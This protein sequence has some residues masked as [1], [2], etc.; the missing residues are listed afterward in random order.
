MTRRGFTLFEV[1]VAL[2][3]F[4]IAVTGLAIGLQS[5]VEA[6]LSARQRALA[7]FVIESRLAAAMTD[8]PL[9]GKRTIDGATN[10]GISV[11]ETFEQVELQD[12]NGQIIPGMWKLQVTAEFGRDPTK[13]QAEILVYRP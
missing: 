12:T 9:D 4:A 13:E 5:A 3:V 7:R 1:L 10:N 8:P 6:A 11:V 2:G